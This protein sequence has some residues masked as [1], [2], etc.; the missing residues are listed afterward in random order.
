MQTR[1]DDVLRQRPS[2]ATEDVARKDQMIENTKKERAQAGG[3]PFK[4]AKIYKSEPE[5]ELPRTV[6]REAPAGG[7]R[8]PGIYKDPRVIA[9]E[10]A[11][12]ITPE[13]PALKELFGTTREGLYE[14]SQQGRRQGNLPDPAWTVQ[15][16]KSRGSAAAEGVM[17]PANEQ[18]ILDAMVEGGKHRGVLLSD[19]WYVM[20]PAY[21][22]LEYLHGP[23]L[24]KRLYDRMNTTGAMT[25]PASGV[26]DEIRRGTAANMMAHQGQFPLW[27]DWAGIAMRH[28]PQP[29][30]PFVPIKGETSPHVEH[31]AGQR[32]PPQLRQVPGHLAHKTAHAGPIENYLQRGVVEMGT[33]K[34]P[35]YIPASG[36]PETGFQTRW[37]VPDA[38]I[39]KSLGM[40]DT[41]TQGTIRQGASMSMP[42]YRQIAPWYREKI[43]EPLGV[44]AVPAQARQW[45][46][47]GPQTGVRTML[48]APKLELLAQRIWERAL[49][50]GWD[51]K[52]LRD[53][54][55]SGGAHAGLAAG[56]IGPAIGG[57][58][59]EQD[60]RSFPAS[61]GGYE[62]KHPPR[63]R[64]NSQ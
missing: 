18:R 58:M 5:P 9:R 4:D 51:P 30:Q 16:E 52:V 2:W 59:G 35:S 6:G 46:L 26:W 63:D 53:Q 47:F 41:R 24:A 38:H 25:S 55:L 54:V 12:L 34:V 19:A 48:G 42:E 14:M 50:M 13:H 8:S 28:R 62:R 10:A 23:E 21:Q 31:L 61:G 29:G 11:E 36:V 37:M 43:A 15:P 49:E 44:E 32:F 27:R 56:I 60:E 33:P 17:N 3:R 45:N 7:G 64:P 39:S 1:A 57:L 40:G 22:R 20:D